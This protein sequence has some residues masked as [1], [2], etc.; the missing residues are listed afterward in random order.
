MLD[1]ERGYVGLSVLRC[2]LYDQRANIHRCCYVFT[3]RLSGQTLEGNRQC[4]HTFCRHFYIQPLRRR[5]QNS[6]KTSSTQTAASQ[7]LLF[8]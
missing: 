6:N 7:Q 2:I 8:W 4:Q 3:G 5:F 1:Q